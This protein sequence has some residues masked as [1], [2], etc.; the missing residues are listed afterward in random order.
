M[1]WKN[2]LQ[3]IAGGPVRSSSD[4]RAWALALLIL[5]AA[6]YFILR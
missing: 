6:L 1:T 5:M 3:V 2:P 4:P